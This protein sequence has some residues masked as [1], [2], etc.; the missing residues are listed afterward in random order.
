MPG[1]VDRVLLRAAKDPAFREALRSDRAQAAVDAGFALADTERSVLDAATPD[2][3]DKMIEA[4]SAREHRVSRGI[5]PLVPIAAAAA[6]VVLLGGAAAGMLLV[7][8]SRP[9]EPR[10]HAAEPADAGDDGDAG[11]DEDAQ[12]AAE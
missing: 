11:D 12:D 7:T 9:D 3:L 1:G 2:Q 4:L 6:G 5:R 10:V 8:G